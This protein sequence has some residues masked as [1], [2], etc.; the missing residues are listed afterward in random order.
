[1][2]R[3]YIVATPIGNLEDLTY[4]AARVLSEVDLVVA[5]D[6]RRAKTL[7]T[8]IGS[9]RRVISYHAESSESREDA[10]VERLRQGDV[11]LISDAGTPGVSD[12]G[13]ELVARA[14]REGIPVTPIPGA[15][16]LVTALSIVTFARQPVTFV[17]F[18]PERRARRERLVR[19][20]ATAAR[21]LVIYLPP[22]GAAELVSELAEWL[23]DVPVACCRELTKLFEEIVETTLG[24]LTRTFAGAPPMGEITLVI[25]VAAAAPDVPDDEDL[26]DA[27]AEALGRGLSPA[28]AS[29]EVARAFR[30][31]KQRVYALTADVRVEAPE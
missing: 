14:R 19:L 4:R 31:P 1:M 25:D 11:A 12:P 18:L 17:G 3:L 26:S 6:T 20:A 13:P 2:G 27:L 22:H 7:L 23:G 28:K 24:S 10:I 15:S 16:A 30:V 8:H 9:D 5:E 29:A 21:T